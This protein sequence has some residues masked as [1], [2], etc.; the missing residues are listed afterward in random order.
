M[1]LTNHCYAVTGLY[2]APPWSVNAGFIA[3]KNKTLIID[4][5][6]NATS[7]QTIYGYALAVALENELL[8]VNTEKHL[9]HVGGNAYFSEKGITIY[10]HPSIQRNQHELSDTIEE[11]NAGIPGIVRRK[12]REGFIAFDHTTVKNPDIAIDHEIEFDLGEIGAQVILTPG[13]TTSN[14]S[15]YQQNEKVLYCGDC[16]LPEF[17]PNLEEGNV[18]EWQSWL[19]SIERIQQLDIETIVPGH[20]NVLNGKTN[21]ENEIERIKTIIKTAITNKKAPTIQ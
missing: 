1:K 18:P 3:G 11:I 8:L 19:T 10:G 20:G 2:F 21:V 5:G 15:V 16:I 13:H 12:H 14:I 9:D 4:A 7:A 17:I 6:S